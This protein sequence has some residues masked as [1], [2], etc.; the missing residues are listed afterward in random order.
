MAVTLTMLFFY[1]N[2]RWLYVDPK[3]LYKISCD[4]ANS[5]PKEKEVIQTALVMFFKKFQVP[6]PKSNKKA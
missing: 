6:P 2:K 5:D 1:T 3:V 4:V